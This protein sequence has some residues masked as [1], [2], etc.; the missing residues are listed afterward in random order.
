MEIFE[1]CCSKAKQIVSFFIYTQ[2][3]VAL[4]LDSLKLKRHPFVAV[5]KSGVKLRLDPLAGESFT[6]F[7]NFVRQDYLR[8]G[9]ALK[10]GD[11]VVDIGANIGAFALLAAS[12]VG[13]TGRVIAIEPAGRT[14]ARLEENVRLND[15]RNLICTRAAIDREPGT[16][17]LSVHPK[18]ALSSAHNVNANGDETIEIVLCRTLAQ[19]FA[20]YQLQHVDLLKVDCEGSEY[21]IFESLSQEL[22]AIVR[23]IAMEVHPV[24]GMAYDGIRQSLEELGFVVRQ[25]PGCPW[26][27]FNNGAGAGDTVANR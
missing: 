9:V 16:L 4:T 18:S 10:T 13:P 17:A 15:F 6:F 2:T 3:P 11:T 26:V 19:I 12:I 14:F 24:E 5:S 27:A 7:E 1:R 21:G 22:A 23:Q 8:N 20:E 25:F